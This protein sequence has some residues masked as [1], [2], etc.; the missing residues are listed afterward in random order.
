MKKL[1]IV[2]AILL[3]ISF[4]IFAILNSSKEIV[5]IKG[6]KEKT[7]LQIALNK[8]KDAHC[9]M[10]IDGYE[11]SSQAI[12]PDGRTWFFHDLGGMPLFLAD[13]PFR[14]DTIMWVY[15]M[16]TNE[17]IDAKKAFYSRTENSPMFYGF[18]AYKTA[19]KAR[20]D[21]DTFEAMMLRGE[22][23][24]NPAV[25]RKLLNERN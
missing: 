14:K 17:Y 19:D 4:V 5:V 8:T 12:A 22:N 23:L 3:L 24:T 20:V 7:P 6:N 9:G 2:S 18:G 25:K 11:F 21:F 15:T 16:D 1:L 10:I 13:K